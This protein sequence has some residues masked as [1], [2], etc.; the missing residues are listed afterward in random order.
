MVNPSMVL[1]GDLKKVVVLAGTYHKVGH[2]SGKLPLFVG[3]VFFC[4]ETHDMV[5]IF[6]ILKIK[7]FPINPLK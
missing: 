5:K 4:Y 7:F 1:R 2:P 3:G 6:S